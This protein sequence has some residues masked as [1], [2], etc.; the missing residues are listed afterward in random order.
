M[1][2]CE[3]TMAWTYIST[4]SRMSQAMGLHRIAS[5]EEQGL[6]SEARQKAKLFWA[7]FILEK[8]LSLQLGR[9][10]TLRDHDI[11][12]PLKHV[13][14]AFQIGGSLGVLS[15]KWLQMS[16]IE[17]RVYD[18]IYSPDALQQAP[19]QRDARAM[20]LIADMN[21]ITSNSNNSEA[22]LHDFKRIRPFSSLQWLIDI[23][24]D[25]LQAEF[26]RQR[27]HIAGERLDDVLTQCEMVA[28]LSLMCLIY[29]GMSAPGDNGPFHNECINTARQ[30]LAEHHKSMALIDSSDIHLFDIFINWCVPW[31]PPVSVQD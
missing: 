10:S 8:N 31:Y 14:T 24:D 20:R 15:P 18:E 26:L 16:Q 2:R 12:I 5:K 11:T 4:A 17:G 9:S 3:A 30:A 27:R 23:A 6:N 29:R 22:C 1:S 28:N 7:M 25:S 13:R 21:E 19:N